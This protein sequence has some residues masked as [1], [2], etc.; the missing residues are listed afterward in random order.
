MLWHVEKEFVWLYDEEHFILC[1]KN[2]DSRL[3]ESF[4]SKI[5]QEKPVFIQFCDDFFSYLTD[6]SYFFPWQ[7]ILTVVGNCQNSSK[8]SFLKG[9]LD[10][11]SYFIF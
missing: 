8:I 2:D 10:V 5:L 1:C 3:L 6:F 7:K 11:I 4:F 9:D